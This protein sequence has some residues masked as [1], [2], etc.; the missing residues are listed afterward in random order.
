MS[1]LVKPPVSNKARSVLS[2]DKA[3]PNF[4][5]YVKALHKWFCART[6]DDAI[7]LYCCERDEG[8]GGEMMRGF[9]ASEIGSQFP[10][11]VMDTVNN[12]RQIGVVAYNGNVKLDEVLS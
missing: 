7:A 11:Y 2:P 4:G 10:L 8:T 6:L 1:V 3:R 12:K 5:I 9:G